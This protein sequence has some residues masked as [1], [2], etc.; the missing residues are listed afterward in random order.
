ML[1][2]DTTALVLIDVQEKLLVHIHD[3]ERLVDNLVQLIRGVRILELPIIWC[4]QNPE[5]IGATIPQLTEHLDGLKPITKMSFSCYRNEEFVRQLEATGAKQILLAGIESHVCVYQTAV[6]L[7]EAGYE[8][9]VVTDAISS[10]TA[11]NRRL[12]LRRMCESHVRPTSTEMALF[13]LL[14]VAEGPK[15]KEI[16]QI[17]K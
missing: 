14:E 3:K 9:Q 1:K 17:V 4:E 7:V 6:Q 16:L 2:T 15:F 11:A 5:K 8:V 13:E 10:R 12:G